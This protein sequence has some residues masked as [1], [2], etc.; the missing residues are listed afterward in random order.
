MDTALKVSFS[1]VGGGSLETLVRSF[2]VKGFGIVL[3][4]NNEGTAWICG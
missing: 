3:Y 1:L 2:M 4:Y